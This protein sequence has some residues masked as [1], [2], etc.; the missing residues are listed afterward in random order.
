MTHRPPSPIFRALAAALALNLAG[1][2]NTHQAPRLSNLATATAADPELSTF[3]RLVLQA[4]VE[5]ALL[6]ATPVTVFA[7]NDDAFKA[8]PPAL[9]DKLARDPE[10]LRI[11]LQHHVVPGMVKSTDIA[12]G[13]ALTS[14]AGTQLQVSRAGDYITVDEGLLTRG[15]V[16]VG[17]GVLHVI[18]SVSVPATKK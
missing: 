17:N 9:R 10:F 3:R 14:A 12:Q 6:G 16:I 18:D 2:A 15:D 4:G 7:P 5:P 1:C 11:V 13:K 8:L